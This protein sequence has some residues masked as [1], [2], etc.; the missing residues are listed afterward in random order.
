MKWDQHD[1]L[2]KESFHQIFKYLVER[3]EGPTDI[4]FKTHFSIHS[5]GYEVTCKIK[6][7]ERLLLI[8]FLKI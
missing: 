8:T 6:T 5:K 2:Q 7:I 1:Q 4:T 3:N